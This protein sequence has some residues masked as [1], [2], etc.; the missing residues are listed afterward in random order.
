MLS[1]LKIKLARY[2]YISAVMVSTYWSTIKLHETF[3]QIT[4]KWCATQTLDC[5]NLFMWLRIYE[6]YHIWELWV[7]YNIIYE[8]FT[9]SVVCVLIFSAPHGNA[10]FIM[11]ENPFV[12]HR[13]PRM[14]LTSFNKC[15]LQWLMMSTPWKTRCWKRV[16]QMPR[17][18]TSSPK[19]NHKVIIKVITCMLSSH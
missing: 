4:Q 15:C 18:D 16:P 12:I 2:W 1:N 13:M 3:Q 14:L 10:K 5:K 7:N 9:V 19:I 6:I 8:H 17:L 11:K